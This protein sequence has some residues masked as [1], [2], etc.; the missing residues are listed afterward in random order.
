MGRKRVTLKRISNDR[1]RKTTFIQRKKGLTKKISEF[2]TMFGAEACLIVYGDDISDL[3]LMTWPQDPRVVRSIIHKYEQSKNER[4]QKTFDI[5]QF[6]ENKKKVVEAEIS[7]VLKEITNIKYPTWNPCIANMEEQQ[8]RVLFAHVDAKI[9]A[10]DNM[11]KHKHQ[12]EANSGIMQNVAQRSTFSFHQSQILP[13]SMEPLGDNNVSVEFTNSMNQ[14]DGVS[15]YGVNMQQG[16]PCFSHFMPNM[17]HESVNAAFSR[18]SQL[19]CLQNIS[20]SQS[21]FEALKPLS[22]NNEM[23]DFSNQV[24]VPIDSTNQLGDSVSWAKLFDDVEKW[25]NESEDCSDL[26]DGDQ[27]NWVNQHDESFFQNIPFQSQNEQ[28]GGAFHALPPPLD[29]FQTSF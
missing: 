4:S 23:V 8:L 26:L 7:K 2:C 20:Q 13:A 18:S 9:G 28:R 27:V 29:G 5:Q 3:G 15:N 17:A 12:S 6:F 21:T 10:C 22:D 19:N 11:L 25:L 14:F 24:D 16:G 1:T